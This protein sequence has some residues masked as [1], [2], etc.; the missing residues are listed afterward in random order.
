MNFTIKTR[1]YAFGVL[2][3]LMVTVLGGSAWWGLNHSFEQ[4][5][6]MN[7]ATLL[8]EHVFEADLAH[9]EMK[10]VVLEGMVLAQHRQME[11]QEDG[12]AV[13]ASGHDLVDALDHHEQVSRTTLQAA[14]GL[15][16]SPEN[17]RAVRQVES[18]LEDFATQAE[19]M[20]NLAA[21]D[22]EAAYA[23]RRQFDLRHDTLAEEMENLI[24]RAE[25]AEKA[26]LTNG[27][28]SIVRVEEVIGL[29]SLLTTILMI[30]LSILIVRGIVVPL[31]KAVDAMR[32]VAEG[33]GDLTRRLDTSRRDELA[34]L[35]D[36]YNRF[37]ERLRGVMA[38]IKDSAVTLEV[39]AEE[40]SESNNDFSSRT[41][42]Q[43]AFLEETASSM[44]EMTSGVQRS[45]ENTGQANQLTISARDQAEQGSKV[46]GEAV[47]SM[48]GI[49][50]SSQKIA[51]II[52]MV[53]E[54]AFQTNLL[55]LNAAVEAARAGEHGRG[56]AVVAS[57]VR[58]LAQRA[59]TAADDIKKLI[60]DSVGKISG[61]AKLVEQTG[62][63]LEQI[64]QS[65]ARAS[66][67]V[68]E[69]T[70]ASGEQATGISEVN[71]TISL[72]DEAT[73]ENA[74][75][76]EEAAATSDTL[77]AEATRMTRLMSFFKTGDEGTRTLGEVRTAIHKRKTSGNFT[78][79]I[80]DLRE[81]IRS[82]DTTVMATVRT[83]R[84]KKASAKRQ[85]SQ[86]ALKAIGDLEDF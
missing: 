77:S 78:E 62:E 23:E 25:E 69:I 74:A 37:A 47:T 14:G 79:R 54:I 16:L 30:T 46:V 45:A 71:R 64:R 40:L 51:E 38:E 33:E 55:A 67:V 85:P 6:T 9:A 1:L 36:A 13:G 8:M 31:N 20:L 26:A 60:E 81:R 24:H 44:E 41:Q 22:V 28:Q 7:T 19:R 66:D 3:V 63:A 61:G 12:H 84:Q 4:F 10:A 34:D 5:E 57:E 53:G 83:S 68:Q 27:E 82:G 11:S 21:T 59:A 32:D 43:A 75:M 73:Q 2:A 39:A 76:V 48:R 86:P 58:N 49:N 70:A 72:L 17:A 29:V 56:F 18:D 65:V 15:H 50:D 42:E 80:N 35:A 52:G